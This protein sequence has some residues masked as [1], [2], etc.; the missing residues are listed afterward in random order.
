MTLPLATFLPLV[1]LLVIT[2]GAATA[3]VVRNSVAGGWRL[4]VSTAVGTALANSTYATA[5]GLGVALVFQRW[6]F[7]L[8]ILRWAGAAYLGWLGGS[9][10][11]RSI[12][13]EASREPR[14]RESEKQSTHSSFAQGLAVNLLNP[15]IIV[16]YLVVVPTFMPPGAGLSVFAALAS[17]HVTMAFVCHLGWAFVFNRLRGLARHPGSL[18]VLDVGTAATLLYLAVRTLLQS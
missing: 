4:G 17:I 6:P 7:A 13:S 16:F 11:R 8:M 15:P 14:D 12:R 9:S 18:R 10:L 5:A 2:P 3:V 1:F